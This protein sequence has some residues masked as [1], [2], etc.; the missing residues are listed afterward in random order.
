[1]DDSYLFTDKNGKSKIKD[2]KLSE[3]PSFQPKLQPMKRTRSSKVK[4]KKEFMQVIDDEENLNSDHRNDDN[5]GNFYSNHENDFFYNS[6]DTVEDSNKH[7]LINNNHTELLPQIIN[8]LQVGSN[9]NTSVGTNSVSTSTSISSEFNCNTLNIS[10]IEMNNNKLSSCE[11]INKNVDIIEWLKYNGFSNDSANQILAKMKA[12]NVDNLTRLKIRLKAVPN[13]LDTL[14]I[15]TDD[16]IDLKGLLNCVDDSQMK[17][18]DTTIMQKISTVTN[19]ASSS[20]ALNILPTSNS[21]LKA[22]IC[23]STSTKQEESQRVSNNKKYSHTKASFRMNK[24]NAFQTLGYQENQMN[25]YAANHYGLNTYHHPWTNQDFQGRMQ[26]YEAISHY[27]HIRQD[28]EHYSDHRHPS[29]RTNSNQIDINRRDYNSEYRQDSE[30]ARTLLKVENE[31]LNFR[32]RQE[33]RR[34]EDEDYLNK[35]RKLG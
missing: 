12:R 13:F 20:T 3:L 14:G 26:G 1:M 7:S 27:N 16:V 28:N 5:S 25:N 2:K 17:N 29:I 34:Y 30:R 10:A 31:F 33:I 9:S 4:D 6:T 8:K 21:S 15:D 35:I 18:I 11:Q 22:S 32:L 19:E 23:T 24:Q